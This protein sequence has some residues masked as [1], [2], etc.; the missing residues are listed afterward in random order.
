MKTLS[1]V[2]NKPLTV[3]F[4]ESLEEEYISDQWK[5][6]EIIL[7]YKKSSK[8]KIENYR[9]INLTSNICKIFMKILKNRMYNQL[10]SNQTQEQA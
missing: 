7:L 10:D 3:L 5:K 1:T 6:V 9:P 8:E 4:N 2:L